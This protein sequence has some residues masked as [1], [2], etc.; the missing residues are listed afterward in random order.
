MAQA[1]FVHFLRSEGLTTDTGVLAFGSLA[2][3]AD[4]L[5][6]LLV[7]GLKKRPG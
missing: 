2:H 1:R 5:W 4:D 7:L 3:S 6:R